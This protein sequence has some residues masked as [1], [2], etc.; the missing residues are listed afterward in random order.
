MASLTAGQCQGPLSAEKA[1]QMPNVGFSLAKSV[2]VFQFPL[3]K[4]K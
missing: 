3:K 2:E 1:Q 4:Q